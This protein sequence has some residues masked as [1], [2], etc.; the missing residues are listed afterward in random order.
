MEKAE[1]SSARNYGI[2]KSTGKYICFLDDDDYILPGYLEGFYHFYEKNNF[3]DVILRTGFYKLLGGNMTKSTNFNIKKHI[4]PVRYAKFNM[5]GIWSLSIPSNFL[6]A[7][8]FYVAFPHW[9]D[10]HLILRLFAKHEFIQLNT[11]E[12]VY[13]IHDK[14]GSRLASK[15]DGDYFNHKLIQNIEPIEHFFFHYGNLVDKYLPS[16]T[17]KYLIAKKYNEFALY[18]LMFSDGNQFFSLCLKGFRTFTSFRFFKIYVVMFREV[19]K[20][21]F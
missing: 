16:H 2:K 21:G 3:S 8:N 13:R 10:T 6:V 9:Q 4:N 20:K 11:Y 12:Y 7:D 14:M 1:R 5:C 17:K 15:S 19:L 18:N